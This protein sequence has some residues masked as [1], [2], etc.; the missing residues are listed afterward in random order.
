[1]S[2]TVKSKAPAW[3]TVVSLVLLVL[4]AASARVNRWTT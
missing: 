4:L 3:F 2:E 1:M